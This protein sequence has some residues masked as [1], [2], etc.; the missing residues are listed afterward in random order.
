MMFKGDISQLET[1]KDNAVVALSAMAFLL[2][3]G[4]SPIIAAGF[5]ANFDSEVGGRFRWSPTVKGDGGRALG[6]GQWQGTR[7]EGLMA[8]ASAIGADPYTRTTQLLFA[9][10]EVGMYPDGRDLPGF[11][12]RGWARPHILAALT[13]YEC[14]AAI[15]R[16]YESPRDL[17]RQMSL[18]GAKA[19]RMKLYYDNL[20]ERPHDGAIIRQG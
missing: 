4:C 16:Y 13:A 19:E 14:G 18:R 20:S 7:Q 17:E 9:L 6:L 5:V 3:R 12:L 11:M 15:S 1:S 8:F 10:Q 2:A